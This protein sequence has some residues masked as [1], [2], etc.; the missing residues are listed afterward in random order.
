MLVL[1]AQ[2]HQFGFDSPQYLRY[3]KP[4]GAELH[5][6]Y[7][8]GLRLQVSSWT[9]E[10]V[11]RFERHRAPLSPLQGEQLHEFLRELLRHWMLADAESA[12][13]AAFDYADAQRGFVPIAFVA[14]L[15]VALPVAIALLADSHQQF[16]C[17][18]ELQEHSEP[19]LMHAVKVRKRDSRTFVMNF[20]Y[21]APNGK[22]IKGTEE[23]LTEKDVPPP[24]EYPMFYSPEH[25]EC[26]SLTKS[27]TEKEINWGKRRYFSWF[28]LLFGL[29]FLSVTFLGFSWC[30]L[31]WF[32]PRPYASEVLGW[33]KLQ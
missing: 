25:P 17:T 20:E 26:Y 12:R 8:K 3:R 6:P 14:C 9:G 16:R 31:R 4:S 10:I 18:R 15:L 11:L 32:R 19:G 27:L 33:V 23:L 5:F 2:G 1:N 24:M 13:K 7:K 29:F 28:G 21:Q 22:L 30:T